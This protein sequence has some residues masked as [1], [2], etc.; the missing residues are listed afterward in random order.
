M[1]LDGLD[2]Q[3]PQR[4]SDRVEP[5]KVQTINNFGHSMRSNL[6]EKLRSLDKG[7]RSENVTHSISK[8]LFK[9]DYDR[10]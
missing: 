6:R 7:R 5:R 4:V 8:R 3:Q 10:L 9:L 1:G 2:R